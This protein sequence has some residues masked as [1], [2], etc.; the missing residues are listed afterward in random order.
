MNDLQ[1]RVSVLQQLEDRLR[2]MWRHKKLTTFSAVNEHVIAAE[3][4]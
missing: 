4:T 2:E 3:T 1:F